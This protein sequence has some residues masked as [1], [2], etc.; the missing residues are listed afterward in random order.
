MSGGFYQIGFTVRFD[1]GADR[2][3]TDC[4][5]DCPKVRLRL[6]WA[7]TLVFQMPTLLSSR[8]RTQRLWCIQR[9]AACHRATHLGTNFRLNKCTCQNHAFCSCGSYLRIF[10][11]LAKHSCRSR[12]WHHS[13]KYP[14]SSDRQSIWSTLLRSSHRSTRSLYTWSHQPR[15]KCLHLPW[16]H[17]W[18]FHDNSYHQTRLQFLC[19]SKCLL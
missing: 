5:N 4:A 6:C 19:R 9:H 11:H 18:N 16:L 13:G 17:P 10:G 2:V 8:K 7:T 3:A 14:W 1:Q 12:A 15:S